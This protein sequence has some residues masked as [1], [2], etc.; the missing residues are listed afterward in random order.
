[1]IVGFGDR[2]GSHQSNAVRKSTR[3][4]GQAII[5]TA[6]RM[7]R[8]SSEHGPLNRHDGNWG[9]GSKLCRASILPDPPT[10]QGK[11]AGPAPRKGAVPPDPPTMSMHK[12]TD[13]KLEVVKI[14]FRQEVKSRRKSSDKVIVDFPK[15]RRINSTVHAKERIAARGN[16]I[17][18]MLSLS[19]MS[20]DRKTHTD[21]TSFPEKHEQR[22]SMQHPHASMRKHHNGKHTHQFENSLDWS[23]SSI[24]WGDEEV[25]S[26]DEEDCGI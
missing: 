19:G 20:L 11:E 17:S 22:Q 26:G 14:R 8:L 21:A 16:P 2:D 23:Q 10:R 3:P 4:A 24:H 1:M 18:D 9:N 6:D 15:E 25:L 5:T 13:T 12:K 7:R